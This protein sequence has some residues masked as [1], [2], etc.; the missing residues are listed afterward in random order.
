MGQ[1]VCVPE[2]VRRV[3]LLLLLRC[4][5]GARSVDKSAVEERFV[6][7]FCGKQLHLFDQ[8]DGLHHGFFE[9]RWNAVFVDNGNTPV[10]FG[11]QIAC[12]VV[13]KIKIAARCSGRV[14][15]T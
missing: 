10:F 5:G 2:M 14:Q 13:F 12:L 8:Q 15:R 1:A 11:L 7:F 3:L 4:I 6:S 9:A